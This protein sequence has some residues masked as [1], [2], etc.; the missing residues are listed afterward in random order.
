MAKNKINNTK[1]TK[2]MISK[3]NATKKTP[4]VEEQIIDTTVETVE[5]T[6]VEK[7]KNN[8]KNLV[9]RNNSQLSADGQVNLL[10]LAAKY[11][12]DDPDAEG[13]YGKKVVE[14]MNRITAVGIVVAMADQAVNGDS[15]IGY[16]LRTSPTAYKMLSEVASDMGVKIPDIKT[17]PAPNDNGEIVIPGNKVKVSESTKEALKEENNLEKKGLNGEI[18][19][20]P[21]KVAHMSEEDLKK[22]L[23]YILI[24]NFKHDRNVKESLVKAVDFMHDYKIEIAR[25]AENSTEAM[26]SIEDRNMR[27]W[28]SE[29]FSYVEP[30]VYM[31]GIGEGM[32]TLCKNEKSPLSAFLIFRDYLTNKKTGKPEWDDQS[33]A[34]AVFSIVELMCNNNIAKETKAKELLDSKAKDYSEIVAK[35]DE[36]INVNKNILE[37]ITNVNFDILDNMIPNKENMT[38][39]SAYGRIWKQYYPECDAAH[40]PGY[41]NLKENIVQQGGIILNLFRSAGNK[42]Q[43]YDPSNL[44]KIETY[45]VAEYENLQKKIEEEKKAAKKDA[46]KKD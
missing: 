15:A 35:Y 7:V 11:F 23:K 39:M 26:N 19:L 43:N 6:I 28:L 14:N 34:D 5:E 20:D 46:L 45:S 4:I 22:A 40:V 33:I 24:T 21:V 42:N 10:G 31:K 18:E 2:K 25:Q 8:Q 27:D 32:Y 13:K 17:L 37:E 3:T 29:I 1:D 36:S 41:K 12:K 38:K 44:S 9:S 30:T 16:A